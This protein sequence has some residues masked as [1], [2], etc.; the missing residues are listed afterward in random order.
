LEDYT[1]VY[2]CDLKRPGC[3]LLQASMGAT[4][5]NEKLAQLDN[6]LLFPTDGLKLYPLNEEMFEIIKGVTNESS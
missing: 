5:S 4:I 6:W 1:I 3:A 2:D